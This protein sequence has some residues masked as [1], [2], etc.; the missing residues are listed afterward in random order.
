M[1]QFIPRGKN[2]DD[3]HKFYRLTGMNWA[4]SEHYRR[5]RIAEDTI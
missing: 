4:C 2:R 5:S 3:I 1:G